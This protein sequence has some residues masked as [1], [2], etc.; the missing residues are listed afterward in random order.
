MRLFTSVYIRTGIKIQRYGQQS[1]SK[2]PLLLKTF[3]YIPISA[4]NHLPYS[5][6][7][8]VAA[9]WVGLPPCDLSITIWQRFQ[10]LF[11][12]PVDNGFF[13]TFRIF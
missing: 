10:V 4:S 13:L 5:A 6:S 12:P 1:T 8:D 3:P 2:D 11:I 9:L 7:M